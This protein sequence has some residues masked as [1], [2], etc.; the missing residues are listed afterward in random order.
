LQGRSAIQV[1]AMSLESC[2]DWF[3]GTGE[4]VADS[5]Y[6]AAPFLDHAVLRDAR[7]I[8]VVRHPMDVINSFVIGLNYFQQWIPPD[9]WHWFMYTHVPELR[10][11]HHPLARAALYYI[12]WNQSIEA[13][14]AG[15][16]YF[17]CQV[18]TITRQLFDYLGRRCDDEDLLAARKVNS[19][20]D[21][22]P[23]YAF[24]DI[25]SAAIRREL[26][27]LA[28]RY[29]YPLPRRGQRRPWRGWRVGTCK[30][31]KRGD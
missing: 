2:G 5:S 29:G 3:H 19:R 26:A 30:A 6:M 22:K 8:H 15:K 9:A 21:G 20:M 14:S 18:E 17:F 24:E 1:S 7:V 23:A 28:E 12:R 4:V 10:L 11:D 25:P 13:R 31:G 27:D 16:P